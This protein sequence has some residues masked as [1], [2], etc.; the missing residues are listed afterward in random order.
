MAAHE[1]GATVG[2]WNALVRRARMAD[3]QKLAA[4][5]F[6]SYADPDG[7]GIHCGVARLAVD[8]GASYRTAQRYLSWLRDVGLIELV[9][10]GNR[11]R[12]LSDEYRLIIGPDIL[13][14]LEVLDPDRYNEA[15]DDLR[16]GRQKRNQ[17]S[18]KNDVRSSAESVSVAGDQASPKASYKD[19]DQ[20]S[21]ETRSG[22]TQDVPPPT[23]N[24]SPKRSTSPTDDE[25]PRT[26]VTGPRA[27]HEEP[28]PDSSPRPKKC[29]HGLGGGLR[30]DGQPEC[31]LCR[32]EQRTGP[33]PP[34]PPD[35]PPNRPRRCDHTPL[36]GKDRCRV[37]AADQDIAPVID[38]NSRRTA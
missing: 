36:P 6:S 29:T 15:R 13:E 35:P 4:L 28:T 26:A 7:T 32:R 25:D 9:R 8:L 31:A 24:T 23:K 17:A 18:P 12:R 21:N 30:T 38:L 22:V 33:P 11:R 14:H 1:L 34:E 3:R 27:S 19:R 16:D 37:C 10:E 5:L 20:A 2:A